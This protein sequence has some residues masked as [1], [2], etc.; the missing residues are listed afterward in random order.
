LE[1]VNS[2]YLFYVL[3][4][5]NGS[6]TAKYLFVVKSF[7]YWNVYCCIYS[8]RMLISLANL[9]GEVALKVTDYLGDCRYCMV[10]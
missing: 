3:S 8:E 10:Y 6:K 7:I 5:K 4:T 1:L 2:V 9:E